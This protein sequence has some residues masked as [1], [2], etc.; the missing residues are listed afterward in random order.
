MS[1]R[2][3]QLFAVSSPQGTEASLRGHD[4]DKPCLLY[5]P[6]PGKCFL[7]KDPNVSNSGHHGRVFSRWSRDGQLG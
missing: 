5:Q 3:S 2:K 1:S 4:G 6:H 7:C